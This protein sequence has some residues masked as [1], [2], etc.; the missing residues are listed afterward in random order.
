MQ[1]MHRAR[2]TITQLLKEKN[3]FLDYSDGH[4]MLNDT[5]RHGNRAGKSSG[6]SSWMEFV[7]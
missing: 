1:K 6:D 2:Q 5:D 7:V 3:A 4:G